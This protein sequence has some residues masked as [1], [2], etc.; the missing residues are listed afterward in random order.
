LNVEAAIQR[1]LPFVSQK[2]RIWVAY[3]GGVDSHVLLHALLAAQNN[4]PQLDIKAVHVHHGLNSSADHWVRHCEAMCQYYQIDCEIKK[5][6][7]ECH[8]GESL[9]AAARIA[10]YQVFQSLIKADDLLLTAHHLDDQAE[11]CFLQFLRGSGLKGLAAM[12]HRVKFYAGH[13][14]RP[15]L[16]VSRLDILQYAKQ[17]H[18]EWIEDDSNHDVRFTRNF[19]R[20]EIMPLLK[21]R[22]PNM[23]ETIMRVSQHTA[24]SDQLL[25]ELAQQ[26]I[27]NI[28]GDDAHILWIDSLKKIS[29]ARQKNVLRFWIAR[30]GFVLPSTV[31]LNQ[32]IDEVLCA[33]SDAMPLVKWKG[34]EIR[35]YQNQLYLLKPQEGF[36]QNARIVFSA[37][38]SLTLPGTLGR[39][40]LKKTRGKGIHSKWLEKEMFVTFRQG[41]ESCCL[42]GRKGKHILKKLFQEWK[43]PVWQRNRIPLLYIENELAAIV[44]YT[45]CEK[46]SVNKDEEGWLPVIEV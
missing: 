1:L 42:V 22:W 33:R 4:F 3:S 39:L 6:N 28:Q 2:K 25:M 43:V 19:L 17:N 46:F 23:A 24:E 38:E 16:N 34:A 18:L 40:S 36:E 11:T 32:I 21:K 41:G 29:Y 30:M 9:E 27:E 13:L 20:Y 45:V 44:G 10:R 12:P 7:I 5:V 8:A 15:F 26:D 14:V 37:N 31:K 35:R